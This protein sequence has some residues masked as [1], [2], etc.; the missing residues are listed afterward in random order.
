MRRDGKMHERRVVD[1]IILLDKPSGISSNRALQQVRG[2]FHAKKAGHTGSLDPLATGLLPICLGE[3]T[4]LSAYLLESDKTYRVE[5]NLGIGT[6][7]GDSEGEVS[8]T[9]LVPSL[10]EEEIRER[11]AAFVGESAQIPPMYSAKKIGGK[12]LYELAREGREVERAARQIRIHSLEFLSC[13]LPSLVFTVSCSKG[14]YIRV[15]VEDIA[16]SMGTVAHVTALRRLE[17]GPFGPE[18]MLTLGE[19]ET[20]RDEGV[21]TLDALLLPIDAALSEVPTVNLS[22]DLAFY[23]RRGTAVQVSKAPA[24]GQV[25]IYEDGG[26]FLGMGEIATDGKVVPKR[27]ISSQQ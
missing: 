11:L 3:A 5:C 7:T 2:I 18:G 1:G 12:R 14:T 13:N 9:G 4:K 26:R 21:S 16:R 10:N 6:N 24:S 20:A 8:I 19:L 17:A 27:L 25:R 22:E 23:L 15:L